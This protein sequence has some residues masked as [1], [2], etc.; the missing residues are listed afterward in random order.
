MANVMKI[1]ATETVRL[2]DA[3]RPVQ[4]L[5]KSVGYGS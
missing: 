5:Q 2:V 1:S 3:F 4:F